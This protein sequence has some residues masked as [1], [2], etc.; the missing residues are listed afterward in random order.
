MPVDKALAIMTE[1]IGTAI[2]P[3]CFAALRQAMRNL[4]PRLRP[5]AYFIVFGTGALHVADRGLRNRPKPAF[6]KE[7]GT[8]F[9][10]L[11]RGEALIVS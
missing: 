7:V 6:V 10:Y 1:M 4:S 3:D 5:Q 2:D 8:E 11:L 9:H